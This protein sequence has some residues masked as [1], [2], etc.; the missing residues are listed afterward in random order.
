MVVVVEVGNGPLDKDPELLVEHM[1][2]T[3][4]ERAKAKDLRK[5]LGSSK[6]PN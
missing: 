4:M 6:G 5:Q 1:L 2:R 3:E